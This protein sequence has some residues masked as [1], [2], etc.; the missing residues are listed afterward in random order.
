MR[1]SRKAYQCTVYNA[2]VRAMS[3]EENMVRILSEGGK[4][5]LKKLHIGLACSVAVMALGLGVTAGAETGAFIVSGGVEGTDYVY[6][7]G[8][9]T[10][11]TAEELTISTSGS[12]ADSI[13]ID[14]AAGADIILDGVSISSASAAM[15]VSSGSGDVVITLA[16]GSE[17]SL[18]SGE[19]Y[20]GLQK[21]SSASLEITGSGSLTARSGGFGAGIG[22]GDAQSVSDIT[23]SGGLI[24]AM[25]G[26]FAA[27][28]GGGWN[29]S[30]R[31]ITISG[32]CV[33]ADSVGGAA[34]IGG[35]YNGTA[36][37]IVITGGSVLAHDTV[38]E[39]NS[40]K[41]ICPGI[42]TGLTKKSDADYNPGEAVAP[43]YSDGRGVY[44]LEV[45]NPQGLDVEVDGV[46]FVPSQH[47]GTNKLYLYLTAEQH[48]I[49]IGGVEIDYFFNPE[50]GKWTE[51]GSAFVITGDGLKHG[52]DFMY[53]ADSGILTIL[54]EKEITIS[55]A[56]PD[57]ATNNVIVVADGVSANITLDGV[58]IETGIEVVSEELT[59]DT[60]SYAAFSIADGSDAGVKIT[61]AAGSENVLISTG[62]Y[63]GL[64]KNGENGTLLISGSG[65]LR[66]EGGAAGIGGENGEEA[67]NITISGT[68]V[69]AIGENGAGIGSGADA[70]ASEIAIIDSVVIATGGTDSA[71]I[72]AGGS[73]TASAISVRDSVVTA[74][75]DGDAAG[76]GGAAAA[77]DIIISGG[78]VNAVAGA[79]AAA[80]IGGSAAVTPSNMM[81]NYVYLLTIDNPQKREVKINGVDYDPDYHSESDTNLYVYLPA[82]DY[83]V[84]VGS[85]DT[86]YYFDSSAKVFRCPE[87]KVTGGR[88]GTDY[89]FDRGA[90]T[91]LTDSAM[92]IEN[93]DKS[94]PATDTIIIGTGVAADIT[95]DGVNID[96]VGVSLTVEDGASL[97][98][99]L[100]AG[101]ENVLSGG[102]TSGGDIF[103]N[104]AG[105]LVSDI[106]STAKITIDSGSVTADDITG[107][108][109]VIT[110]GSVK[111]QGITPEPTNGTDPVYLLKIANPL[112]KDLYIDN[113]AY[114]PTQHSSSDSNVYAYLT[115]EVHS[116]KTDRYLTYHFDELTS[117]F[118]LPD[119][120]VYGENV[121]YGT[122][123]TYSGGVVT[124]LTDTAITI[125]N[126]DPDTATSDTII[127]A[128]GVAADLTLDSVN[129]STTSTAALLIESGNVSVKLTLA[130]GSENY[131]TGG[132]GAAGIQSGTE[133]TISGS[134]ELTANG[135]TD[136][137][138]IYCAADI[139][140]EDSDITA[141]GNANGAGIDSDG[142]IVMNNGS[143]IANAG[144][145]G[146]GINS[147]GIVS[148]NGGSV[149]A[150]GAADGAGIDSVGNIMVTGG[151][152]T[153]NGGTSGS[154]ISSG[155]TVSI[156]GD[157]VTATGDTGI[158]STASIT[159]DGGSVTATGIDADGITS[160][161]SVTVD[162]GAVTTNSIN[163]PD[164][165]VNAGAVD[166]ANITGDSAVINGGSVTA[167]SI[168]SS[169][170]VINGGSVKADNISVDPTNSSGRAVYLLTLAN[171]DN[172]KIVIDG[173]ER[174]PKQHGIDSD[175]NVY[176][177]LT[178]ESHAV[179]LGDE[180]TKTYIYDQYSE[181]FVIIGSDLVVTGGT[182]GLDYTYPVNTGVLTILTDTAMT[183]ENSADVP[184]T[185][186]TIIIDTDVDADITLD[187]V[188]ISISGVALS[189]N[190]GDVKITLADGSDNVLASTG[191]AAIFAEGTGSVTL[192][193]TG[194]LK[195][196]GTAA[197]S[198]ADAAVTFDN[199]VV[200]AMGGVT[201]TSIVI[202]G[203]SVKAD[204]LSAVPTDGTGNVYLLVIENSGNKTITI[205]GNTY[206][207][208]QHGI[209][210]DTNVYAYLRGE[211]QAV[212]VDGAETVYVFD[213][214][215]FK[216]PDLII[217][218]SGV[219]FGT[220]YTY[221]NG[222]VTILTN[223]AVTISNNPDVAETSDR[224]ET[225]AGIT[226][227]ITLDGANINSAA[228]S[229]I[230]VNG[231]AVITL[232]EDSE[233]TLSSTADAVK[234]AGSG[235]LE[236]IGNGS[237]TATDINGASGTVK[238]SS[239]SITADNI[240]A[241]KVVIT[242]G[243]VKADAVTSPVDGDGKPVHLMAISN[244]GNENVNVDGK[245]YAPKQHSSTDSNIYAYIS[246]ESD[247]VIQVGAVK[248]TYRYSVEK[249]KFLIV[250]TKDMFTVELPT[251]L[252]YNGNPKAASVT[253]S[254]AA[255]TYTIKYF[256]DGEPVT[257]TSDA[258]DYTFVISVFGDDKYAEQI[259]S[260]NEWK[261]TVTG[262]ELDPPASVV[263]TV[264]YGYKAEDAVFDTNTGAMAAGGNVVTGT[265]TLEYDGH[266]TTSGNTYTAVFEPDDTNYLAFTFTSVQITVNAVEP[267]VEAD[268]EAPRVIPG[269]SVTFRF[270]AEHPKYPE[271]TEGLPTEI[272]SIS[273][274]TSTSSNTTYTVPEDAEI[275]STIN[276]TLNIA[277]VDG[278]YSAST[279]EAVIT[280]AE[281]NRV[282]DQITVD[283]DNAVYGTDPVPQGAFSGEQDGEAEWSYTFAKGNVGMDGSFGELSELYNEFGALDVGTYTVMARYEDAANIGYGVG[284]FKVTPK[285]LRVGF[286]GEVTKQ[287]DGTLAVVGYTADAKDF[288]L[289]GLVGGAKRYIDTLGV[290]ILYKDENVGEDKELII[291]IVNDGHVMT[292]DGAEDGNYTV[293]DSIDFTGAVI[294]RRSVT[295]AAEN[296]TKTFG[297]ADPTFTY[298]VENIVANEILTGELSREVGE[299]AGEY[300]ITQ[301]TLTNENNANY[302]ITFVPAVLTITKAAAPEDV[303]LE[304]K[305]GWGTH[306]EKTLAVT[307][308]PADMGDI[309]NVTATVSDP[310]DIVADTAAYADGMVIYTLNTNTFDKIGSAAEIT[311]VVTTQ[312]YEDFNVTVSIIITAKEDQD[313][314]AIELE[315][316]LDPDGTFTATIKAVE[317]AEYKFENGDWSEVNYIKGV[318]PS[319][320]VT[321]YIRMAE[322]E[323][324][325]A[326]AAV[327]VT[328]LSPKSTV[329]D[330]VFIPDPG[331][332]NNSMD[333]QFSCPTVGATILYTIDG[334]DPRTN[335]IEY[336]EPVIISKT[337]T[338]NIIA[339]KEGMLDSNVITGKFTKSTGG[340][341]GGGG[342]GGTGGG[343]SD[344]PGGR[345]MA[346]YGESPAIDGKNHNW[347]QIAAMIEALPIGGELEVQLNGC[348][349][350]PDFVI[351]AIANRDAHLT[352]EYN[353]LNHWFVDGADLSDTEELENAYLNITYP[354]RIMTY[355]LRG[356][357]KFKFRISDTKLP[358]TLISD[359]DIKNA[360]EFA[361]VYKLVDGE[362][363]YVDTVIIGEDG[364]AEFT[365]TEKGD[366]VFM[367]SK[368]S[369]LL[370][371]VNNDG[372]V[373][374]LDA[375]A[376]LRHVV[377]LEDASNIEMGDF[378]YSGSINAMDAGAILKWI[379]GAA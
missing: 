124:V 192:T 184:T 76:I 171:P 218:G 233:N 347:H 341:G 68:T 165:T 142:D 370:G 95:F 207:V 4:R 44:L 285:Q 316:T 373:N 372:R 234:L 118:Y 50:T 96:S 198:A 245:E 159:I 57:N 282:N 47:P 294:E 157:T 349:D 169:E 66:A 25:G 126:I 188:N 249:A 53:P 92:T 287:Y 256:K 31:D 309:I 361:N 175:T 75:G 178:G 23:I 122:D 228:E 39:I 41:Y 362:L 286:K 358:T 315:F 364:L 303:Q 356:R 332:F 365:M 302:D 107:S 136:G 195:A 145:S 247:H 264:G 276:I 268:P 278:K 191:A 211:T 251:D 355:D 371:D 16:D 291:A 61:L 193:G 49:T 265:W 104:G 153:A 33:T 161:V 93:I 267:V 170:T 379:V 205:N 212:T 367:A 248:T 259:V 172:K 149:M 232:A 375:A 183:I 26:E 292:A 250:P 289:S 82:D 152:V 353:T 54:T 352:F 288:V 226:A 363:V 199:V 168:D 154:G 139:T 36:G 79:D 130:E 274:G 29:G 164:V 246:G 80:K 210:G 215:K 160:A 135:G 24:H 337:T 123:Y 271:F 19:N 155:G 220:D 342:G 102:I 52:T 88:L 328:E 359:L 214:T 15:L 81:G 201:A 307:G 55:N 74:T 304:A 5:L 43:K 224:I 346:S 146:V 158:S 163:A 13:V 305:H 200:T 227:K 272:I 182:Y 312:N 14:S 235:S 114:L 86:P 323:T 89:S 325:N 10:I 311:L 125:E 151:N 73:G 290:T 84:T 97:Q 186:H 374:A 132:N 85:D 281:K 283:T 83:V 166:T 299:D 42:G 187:G 225:A 87:L 263:Y 314:P 284:T 94:A 376:I 279:A 137:A 260:S 257:D 344:G 30:G 176:F 67:H 261:F 273:D 90:V 150:T 275:N 317:G 28:I 253:A 329:L 72:G 331:A 117:T 366:Y 21:E 197:I 254:D 20:A 143:I 293:P 99:T 336:T 189:A 338:F 112:N 105:E 63:A 116:V 9:L 239:G 46:P 333:V 231:N 133:L 1:R 321:A 229:A 340:S 100:A 277:G 300:D 144:T 138:G 134:G 216:L 280:V 330:P 208:K 378:D 221:E 64:Q 190:G 108:A 295:V 140:I 252:T 306:G 196:S 206:P 141:T 34:S 179:K 70:D 238:I 194:T 128:A 181:Q 266:I 354:V 59:I 320:Y 127:I 111:T 335:G 180:A 101:S 69:T 369:D 45:E 209:D 270:T 339:I 310:D 121:V 322:T 3:R 262:A 301:G 78:S 377:R 255:M 324:H 71:G 103:V 343:G 327:S 173:T 357:A 222:V 32:G 109:V 368:Y 177:Y 156:N 236:I 60:S 56:D 350:V 51:P 58:N 77:S 297:E 230:T 167:T 37:N 91:I 308:V 11:N 106:E 334:T 242:G 244:S 119:L 318:Q 162:S 348:V 35:G 12:T 241:D 213:G 219:R 2:F 203:G 204:S 185:S 129:I 345:P 48:T 131:L 296:A 115:G 6:A 65:T 319:T 258:G 147:G 17:N 8:V 223:K 22:G 237:I 243:S 360:G 7:S 38:Y 113:A 174:L 110:G 269:K 313:P 18:I 202:D 298:V 62:A 120:N 217:S 98:L 240:S 326:S 351:K 148:I 40:K 27:G